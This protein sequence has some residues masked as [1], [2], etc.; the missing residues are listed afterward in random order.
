M[1]KKINRN[2]EIRKNLKLTNLKQKN[3]QTEN[4]QLSNLILKDMMFFLKIWRIIKGYSSNG[5]R[6]HSNNKGNKKNK[7]IFLYRVQ[8]FYQM[9]GRKRRDIFPTLITAEYTNRLWFLVWINKWMEAKLFAYKLALKS[10]KGTKFDPQLIA[11][12]IVT[13][14]PKIRK[15]KK[16]NVAKKKILLVVTIG[17]PVLFSRYLYTLKPDRELPFILMIPDESR[18]KMGKKKRKK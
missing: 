11:K 10:K 6:S 5:Q 1:L 2:W 15:K 8:Q 18:R 14:V 12:N 17:L 16:H 13:G 4:Y 9:F 3:I 7:K